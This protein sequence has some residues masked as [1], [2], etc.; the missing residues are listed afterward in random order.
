[1]RKLYVI[2][3]RGKK[4]PFSFSK[5]YQSARRAGAPKDLAQKIAKTIQKEIYPGI[6]TKKIFRR[7]KSMLQRTTPQAALRFNL[8]EAM[9]KLGPTGFPFEKFAGE[10][11]TTEG[12]EVKF[13]QHIKGRCATYEID[14]VAEKE[15]GLYLGECKYHRRRGERVDLAV[16]LANYARFLDVKEALGK[17]YKKEL[18]R[19]LL[20]TN[21]KFTSKAI[22]YSRCVG[23]ELLGWDWPRGKGLEYLVDTKKLYPITILP[24]FKGRLIDIFSAKKMMLA[25]DLLRE[26]SAEIARRLNLAQKHIDPLIKEAK[27]LLE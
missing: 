12:F 2:N 18:V 21:T 10:I 1:M 4:E 3:S 9:R 19:S 17:K 15:G 16:S 23:V 14:L 20:V 11:L 24:S 6:K 27:I 5:V 26:S 8:K 25:R 22:R 13:N 7:V